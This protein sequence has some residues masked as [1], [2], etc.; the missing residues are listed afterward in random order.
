MKKIKIIRDI[1]NVVLL[2]LSVCIVVGALTFCNIW[3]F[4]VMLLLAICALSASIVCDVKI[5]RF[6]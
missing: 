1:S 4:S 3:I 5:K 2:I 6:E